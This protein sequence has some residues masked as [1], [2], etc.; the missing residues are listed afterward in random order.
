[1]CGCERPRNHMGNLRSVERSNNVRE[2]FSEAQWRLGREC[3][4]QL[5]P[6]KHPQPFLMDLRFVHRWVAA[7]NAVDGH[8][9]HLFREAEGDFDPPLRSHGAVEAELTP[10]NLGVGVGQPHVHSVSGGSDTKDDVTGVHPPRGGVGAD[11]L[12][13]PS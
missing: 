4:S 11:F 3:T 2:E 6:V 7:P 8:C 12:G 1:M 9:P 13:T 10:A 5:G